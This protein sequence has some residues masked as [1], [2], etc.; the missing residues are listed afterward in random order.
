M[1]FYL[2][3]TVFIMAILLLSK[4]YAQEIN[5]E[6]SDLKVEPKDLA[7]I[8][9]D[10]AGTLT[11]KDYSSGEP[12]TMPANLSVKQGKNEY[13]LRLVNTYPNEPKANSEGKLKLSKDE[14]KLNKN[15]IKSKQKLPNGQVQIITEYQ[16]KDNRKKALIRNIYLLSSEQFVIRKEVQFKNSEIWTVRNEYNYIREK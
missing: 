4:S 9:G 10:W 12:Y 15:Q 6:S 14:N 11:Y 16:G 13:E 1:K 7:I 8:I 3:K 5:Q 2:T